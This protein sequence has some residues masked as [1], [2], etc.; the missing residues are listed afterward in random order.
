MLCFVFFF[1]IRFPISI[2]EISKFRK[3]SVDKSFIGNIIISSLLIEFNISKLGSFTLS[4]GSDYLT[5]SGSPI[6]TNFSLNIGG[7]INNINHYL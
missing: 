2:F 6:V 4:A 1:K 5:Y 7:V 3:S